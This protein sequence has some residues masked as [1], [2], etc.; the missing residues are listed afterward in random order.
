MAGTVTYQAQLKGFPSESC[1][2]TPSMVTS[3]HL[4]AIGLSGLP[5]AAGGASV[6]VEAA[7]VGMAAVLLLVGG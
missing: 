5:D 2:A 6:D 4:L 3:V 7:L 1:H